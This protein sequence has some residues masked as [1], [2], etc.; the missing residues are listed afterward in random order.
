M[1]YIVPIAFIVCSLCACRAPAPQPDPYSEF[2]AHVSQNDEEYL[3]AYKAAHEKNWD[4]TWQLIS[5]ETDPFEYTL[6]TRTDTGDIEQTLA[7]TNCIVQWNLK[8]GNQGIIRREVYSSRQSH[9]SIDC[10]YYRNDSVY[11]E[12]TVHFAGESRSEQMLITG[13]FSA[14][15][16][17][18]PCASKSYNEVQVL[19]IHD[20]ISR[21]PYMYEYDFLDSNG[22]AEGKYS[23][24]V[25]AVWQYGDSAGVINARLTSGA[26]I[27]TIKRAPYVKVQQQ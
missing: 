24:P 5:A 8:S 22:V 17:C 20:T 12:G 11:A 23:C 15:L 1:K 13:Y 6:A 18:S 25:Y 9:P 3:R 26:T 2:I 27:N 14:P 4:T 7:D 19:K 21:K 16:A 10:Y